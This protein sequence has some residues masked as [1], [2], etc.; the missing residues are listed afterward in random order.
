MGLLDRVAQKVADRLV[1]RDGEPAKGGACP[2]CGAKADA[3]VSTSL[4]PRYADEVCGRC[5]HNFGKV[6]P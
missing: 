3:R 5:G 4:N 1:E 6:Q 2:S